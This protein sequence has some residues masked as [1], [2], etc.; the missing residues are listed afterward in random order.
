MVS[1]W[2]QWWQP[3]GGTSY[4]IWWPWYGQFEVGWLQPLQ[5]WLGAGTSSVAPVL[6]SQ[7]RDLCHVQLHPYKWCP[8]KIIDLALFAW[9]IRIAPAWVI[10]MVMAP[11]ARIHG[12]WRNGKQ[13]I[14]YYFFF[15]ICLLISI[16][17]QYIS[18]VMSIRHRGVCFYSVPFWASP[19]CL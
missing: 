14:N 10:S 3:F 12:R 11:P 19:G 7:H 15:Q 16:S 18:T 6:V 5:L 13:V 17:M 9:R 4:G 8:S 2:P 1:V